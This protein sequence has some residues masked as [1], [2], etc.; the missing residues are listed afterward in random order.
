MFYEHFLDLGKGQEI[1]EYIGGKNI[2]IM[3]L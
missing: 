1:G 3:N 2:G